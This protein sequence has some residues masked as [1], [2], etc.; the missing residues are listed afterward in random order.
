MKWKMVILNAVI[1]FD[2]N[3][4]QR[5]TYLKPT[6]MCIK[7]TKIQVFDSKGFVICDMI[8]EATK[9]ELH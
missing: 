5:Q 7:D 1:G 8:R 2:D 3:T 6:N 4:C 9:I